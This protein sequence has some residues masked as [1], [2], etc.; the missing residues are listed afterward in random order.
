MHWSFLAPRGANE[1]KMLLVI[2]AIATAVFGLAAIVTP[3][4]HAQKSAPIVSTLAR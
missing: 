2:A 1:S 4:V 3:D